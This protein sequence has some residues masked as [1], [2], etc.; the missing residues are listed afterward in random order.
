MSELLQRIQRQPAFQQL[1]ANSRAGLQAG[2]S[3][4]QLG[5][6]RSARLPLAAAL[7]A[8]SGRPALL[9]THRR[10][11]AL[12]HFEELAFWAP[13]LERLYFPEPSSL[14]YENAPWSETARRERL[15]AL[16]SLALPA[17]AGAPSEA[18]FVTA[19]ARALMSR[20]LPPAEFA[21]AAQRVQRGARSQ[22][23]ELAAQLARLGYE[24]AQN[25]IA[26]GQF[27]RRGGILDLWPMQDEL[28]ARL[29]YFGDE[30]DS[31]RCF[32]PATQRTIHA[33]DELLIPPAREYI[34]SQPLPEGLE[35]RTLTE[36]H[37]PLLHA[38]PAGLLDYLPADAL[39][40]IDDL[41]ALREQISELETQALQLHNENI[42][43][44]T[45]SA[46]YPAP[47]LSLSELEEALSERGAIE[48][49]PTLAIEEANAV[50]A[51]FRPGPRFGGQLKPMLEQVE[52]Y[53]DA[54]DEVLI[55]S[56]QTP[57]LS[58]MWAER[59]YGAGNQADPQF[60][61]GSLA[62]GWSL[63]ASG[64][65]QQKEARLHLLTDGE[66]FGWER[67][68]PRRQPRPES[69][70]PEAGYVDLHNEE[71]V[72][73]IDHGIG[74]FRGLVEAKIE[75]K[76]R[77]F[78]RVEYAGGDQLYVPVHQADRLSRYIGSRGETPTLNRLGGQDWRT[79]KSRVRRAVEA[80]AEDLLELYAKREMAQGHA[81]PPDTPW[82]HE[83]EASFPYVETEDQLRVLAEVKQDMQNLRPMDR[84]VCGDAGYGKTEIALR[85]AFK[86]VM[87]GKQVAMLVPTTV[88]AQQHYETFR[89]RLAAFPVR[90]EML[91]RFRDA[92]QQQDTIRKL[93]AGEM[94][95]VIGTHRMVQ[96]DVNFKDLG[97]V[98]IDEEQ[99]FG[100]THKEH[101]KKLRTEVDVLT[102]TATPIP[103]TLYMALTGVRDIST[104]NTP[105]EERLP[106]VTHVGPYSEQLVR[107]AVLRELDRGG[108]IFFVHNRVHSI[109]SMRM[110]LQ[111]VVPE[112]RIG[113]A[114]GQMAERDLAERMNEFSRG[115]IDLLLT[116]TIIE[117]GLDIPNANTLIVD[118]A[119]A[120]GLAQ[121]YQL[122]GRV[123][124]GA[125]RAYAYFFRH[126]HNGMTEEGRQHLET[127]AEN[128]QHGAG[129]SVAMRDLEIRGAGDLL[130]V[131]QH[132]LI[133]SVGFHLYTRL[134]SKAVDDI[135]RAGGFG[136]EAGALSVT[137]YHPLINVDL[138]VEVGIPASYVSDKAMRLKLYR[139]LADIHDVSE[140]EA[141][142]EEFRDRFG[143]PPAEVQN[144]L[145]QLHVRVLAERTGLTTINVE[146]R[147]LALRFPPPRKKEQPMEFSTLPAGTRTSK[148]TI[149]LS[150]LE[151]ADWRQRLLSLLE[152]LVQQ[153]ALR[154]AVRQEEAEQ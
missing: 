110:Q 97:L 121:L 135:K 83:L 41:D 9:L 16:A 55:V 77:E 81:Y 61:E 93:A 125:Q 120:F 146:N 79:T 46:G 113:V 56:R 34:L 147:Q 133:A 14:F 29:E 67:P 99:R 64:P 5:L 30:L 69:Q 27:A 71:L 103:R 100:V 151:S 73:H 65:S 87:D 58:D 134:L 119:D 1:L 18:Y 6:I 142:K 105:P 131:R 50:N 84:L 66:I 22:P 148:N 128:T 91:S 92:K 20:T 25:V 117:S 70:A 45:V 72:V 57:R 63:E 130:G 104:I 88:L 127:I 36:F 44:G 42:E 19:S 43:A 53:L 33:I 116:T 126:A 124:R 106:I 75:G 102:M 40:L 11:R 47:Y 96:A 94:D 129:F 152:A 28:P 35:A 82:Q 60:A 132:G 76:T 109:E 3:P 68:Q 122:R 114:H 78:L 24:A 4:L 149:W 13:A 112:V 8:A 98:I 23:A 31:L 153:H 26:P 59:N 123:G 12:T 90:I 38:Q 85:A 54:G 141:L 32:D 138:P 154:A 95:I 37:I 39:I 115:E 89:Q 150:D 144:L 17:Q 136:A 108:Q 49:G 21:A 15:A 145:F 86:A 80:I 52:R 7:A 51:M 62:E 118:R 143:A 111:R 2:S 48:L 10:D 137:L 101:L 107:R 74:I 139:R 140:I